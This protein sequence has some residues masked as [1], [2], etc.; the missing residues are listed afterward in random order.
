VQLQLVDWHA[1]TTVVDP[2]P[3]GRFTRFGVQQ[4][5]QLVVTIQT[6]FPWLQKNYSK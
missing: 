4:G 3:E 2:D 6:V 5:R 1:I